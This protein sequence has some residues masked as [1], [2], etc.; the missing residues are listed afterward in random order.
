MEQKFNEVFKTIDFYYE[1]I[2]NPDDIE[3]MDTNHMRKTFQACVS[4]ESAMKKIQELKKETEFESHLSAMMLK[5]KKTIQYRCSNLANACDKM[6]EFFLTQ[7]NFPTEMCDQL[8]KMYVQQCGSVR[9]E[10]NINRILTN[11]MQTNKILQLFKD[12]ELPE[13]DIEDEILIASWE[14]EIKIG[15]RKKVADCVVDMFNKEQIP[16]LIE[17]AYKSETG[18]AVNLMIL[19]YFVNKLADN[20]IPLCLEL[21]DT[22][23]KV[24][25]KLMIDSSK[26]QDSF[27]D[28]TFYIGRSME[29]N[30]EEEWFTETGFFYEDLKNMIKA[31]LDGPEEVYKLTVDRIMLGK[32]LDAVWEDIERDCIL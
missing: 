24:L 12:L 28:A 30:E 16:R 10:V 25:T 17:L 32:E 5:K 2:E 11:C 31:L 22:R 21:K 3:M 23:K 7:K 29:C 4:I 14:Y 8:L 13:S 1:V 15:K 19:D 18:S 6:L 26:F 20:N 9:L 27:I